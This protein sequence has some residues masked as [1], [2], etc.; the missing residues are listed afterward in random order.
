MSPDPAPHPFLALPRT[1][2]VLDVVID[3]DPVNEVDDQFAVAWALLRPDRLRVRALLAATGATLVRGDDVRGRTYL[4][5]VRRFADERS[6]D[7]Q[8]RI[9]LHERLADVERRLGRPAEA[10]RLLLEAEDLAPTPDAADRAS[11]ADVPVV[12]GPAMTPTPGPRA[13]Q[14]RQSAEPIDLLGTAGAPVLKRLAP[15]LG[16]LV[17][18][19]LVLRRLLR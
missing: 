8:D 9:A 14:P 19:V 12:P 1:D 4:L 10:V 3:T 11:T 13:V 2:R 7:V 18:L 17:L 6:V 15:V 16:G 5:R